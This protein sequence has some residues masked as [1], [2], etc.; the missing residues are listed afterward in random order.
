MLSM[1]LHVYL[2]PDFALIALKAAKLAVPAPMRRYGTSVGTPGE[3]GGLN[4]GA[5]SPTE[6]KRIIL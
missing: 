4:T 2:F 3:A 5:V 6:N 1:L